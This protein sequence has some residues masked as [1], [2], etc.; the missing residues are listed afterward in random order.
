MIKYNPMSEQLEQN[1]KTIGRKSK[2]WEKAVW[3]Y[4]CNNISKGK[5]LNDILPE[6]SGALPDFIEFNDLLDHPVRRELYSAAC[7]HRVRYL[8][9]TFIQIANR[10]AAGGGETGSVEWAKKALDT[11][12]KSEH[13]DSSVTI[14]FYSAQDPDLWK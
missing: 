14:N 11:I 5:S 10:F 1:G 12:I 6:T 7:K 8:R 2:A 13:E 9:E 4:I 3:T